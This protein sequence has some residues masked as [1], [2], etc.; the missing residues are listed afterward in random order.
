MKRRRRERWGNGVESRVS[1]NTRINC[2]VCWTGSKK[3]FR[4]AITQS[5]CHPVCLVHILLTIP[6]HPDIY[7]CEAASNTKHITGFHLLPH[8]AALLPLPLGRNVGNL[9]RLGERV[10]MWMRYTLLMSG[11]VRLW[12]LHVTCR[13]SKHTRSLCPIEC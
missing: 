12:R 5:C 9:C 4:L 10:Q 3:V 7:K 13:T 8:P 11:I 2:L 1:E 6:H